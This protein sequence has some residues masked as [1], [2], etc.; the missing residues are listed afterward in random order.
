MIEVFEQGWEK[1]PFNGATASIDYYILC[2]MDGDQMIDPSAIIAF[3]Y[4]HKHD[5]YFYL[6]EYR[7]LQRLRTRND[8]EDYLVAS[9]YPVTH[10]DAAPIDKIMEPTEGNPYYKT[11]MKYRNMRYKSEISKKIEFALGRVEE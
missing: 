9:D 10:C 8:I 2:D 11:W 3:G 6:N 7:A 1:I 4:S 5:V